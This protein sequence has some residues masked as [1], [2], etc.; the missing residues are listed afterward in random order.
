[1]KTSVTFT[2]LTAVSFYLLAF[3]F[4]G[5]S[6]Q[7]DNIPTTYDDIN[8]LMQEGWNHYNAGNF[9]A[10]TESFRQ[11]SQRNAGY[12]PAYNGLGW[13]AVRQTNFTDAE[14]QF[15]FV[16]TVD[17]ASADLQADTYAGLSL[18]SAIE[19][20][21]LENSGEGTAEQLEVLAR[22]S[23]SRTQYVF[24]LKGESYSPAEHD[25]GFGSPDLHLLNAQHY[26]Y[27]QDFDSSEAE[28]SIVDTAFV[29][30]QLLIYGQS[31][32]IDSMVL[33]DTNLVAGEDT[34]WFLTIPP[35]QPQGI[36]HLTQVSM[37]DTSLHLNL[38]YDVLYDQNWI[39]VIPL[40]G[41]QL[42]SGFV[43]NVGYIYV[44]NFPEY[45]FN[46]IERIQEL[47][48]S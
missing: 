18:S 5:C 48:G 41:A 35:S 16:T 44:S 4:S 31:A 17:T 26:F 29:P 25:P 12:L 46:L 40:A 32:S 24:S 2:L 3:S 10:A 30:A 42:D 33:N 6:D 36:H 7:S 43:F 21:A 38:S 23:I 8:V 19:R 20:L 47:I 15:S 11:A 1:M 13:S 37:P 9:T 28:L 22:E 14:V 39:Q 34:I 27:L 45:L